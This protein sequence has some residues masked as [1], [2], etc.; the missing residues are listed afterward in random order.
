MSRSF[1]KDFRIQ[2]TDEVPNRNIEKSLHKKIQELNEK[3][4]ISDQKLHEIEERLRHI[5]KLKEE[6]ENMC[7]TKDS[8]SNQ[9]DNADTNVNTK[10]E[11]IEA[12]E[13]VEKLRIDVLK[14]QGEREGKNNLFH[15]TLS[16][17]E[18][19]IR[20]VSDIETIEI[21][22]N[23]YKGKLKQLLKGKDTSKLFA[24]E[25]NGPFNKISSDMKGI[26]KDLYKLNEDL[27]NKYDAL[28][29]IS[30]LKEIRIQNQKDHLSFLG[31]LVMNKC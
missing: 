6:F 4:K 1:L 9:Q 31:D 18:N 24:Q 20:S 26:I 2:N 28:D 5:K 25:E 15:N 13:E 21:E 22:L 23:A 8:A 17:L 29:Q 30:R 19:N 27:E 3:K 16:V 14:C 7:Q 12:L 10:D 11:M